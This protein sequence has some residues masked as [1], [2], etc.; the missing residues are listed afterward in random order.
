MKNKKSCFVCNEI[1]E[2][3]EITYNKVVNLPVCKKCKNTE[4]EKSA[5]TS[6]LDSLGE[7]FVCGC[8]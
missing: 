1:I 3:E 5:E 4:K 2:I 7:G 8:I 6:A